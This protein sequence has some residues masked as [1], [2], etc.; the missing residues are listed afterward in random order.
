MELPLDANAFSTRQCQV[1]IYSCMG[2][3]IT[4][5]EMAY[6]GFEP[7]TLGLQARCSHHYNMCTCSM[8]SILVFY[9]YVSSTG[10]APPLAFFTPTLRKH[11]D[12]SFEEHERILACDLLG[13]WHTGSKM[14][15]DIRF[16]RDMAT[17]KNTN[18]RYVRESH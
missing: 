14:S 1:T 2:G 6:V 17:L 3:E 16:V 10:S 5:N 18:M 9:N 8:I 15:I 11:T 12:T 4:H 13:T 7:S